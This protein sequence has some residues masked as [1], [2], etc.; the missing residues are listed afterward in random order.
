MSVKISKTTLCLT[1]DICFAI[2]AL[3]KFDI[4]N[5]TILAAGGQAL[6]AALKNNQVITELN[7]AGN[8]LG[9][10]EAYGA[11]D[12][13]GV[14]DI[15][16]AIPTMRALATITVGDKQAVTMTTTMTEADSGGKLESYEAQ[17]VAAFLPK[18]Q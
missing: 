8:Q 11:A 1:H 9:R 2:R 10:K 18:C 6:A 16:N 4:G 17:I 5:N 13:S 3:V 7:V 15:A 14:M 12:L